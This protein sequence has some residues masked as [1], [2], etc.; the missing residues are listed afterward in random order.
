MNPTL[1]KFID[2]QDSII[3]IKKSTLENFDFNENDLMY[4]LN[5]IV[6]FND[7]VINNIIAVK[8]YEYDKLN[9]TIYFQ[10]SYVELN[11]FVLSNSFCMEDTCYSLMQLCNCLILINKSTFENNHVVKG[12]VAIY[13]QSYDVSI[14]DS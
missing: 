14:M 2:I 10:N 6:I 5:S 7:F 1:N 13:S 11:N 4:A 12:T 9:E 8:N 3:I